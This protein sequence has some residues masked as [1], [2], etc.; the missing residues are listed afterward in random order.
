MRRLCG[1]LLMATGVLDILYVLVFHYRQLDAIAGDGYFNAVDPGAAFSTFDRETAFWHLMFGAMALIPGTLPSFL[2][3]VLLALG[4][5]G[6]ILMPV[7][8]FW[9]VLPQAIMLILVARRGR[10]GAVA[11]D[12]RTRRAAG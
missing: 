7:S 6:V 8:G 3:W 9:V 10:P 1:P 4:L 5:G 12:R 2:G 11:G